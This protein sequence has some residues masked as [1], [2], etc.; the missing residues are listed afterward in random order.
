MEQTLAA[1]EYGPRT[2][3]ELRA[4]LNEMAAIPRLEV[5]DLEWHADQDGV[6]LGWAIRRGASSRAVR[7][8]WLLAP[9][10][11]RIRM[12]YMHW[13]QFGK[14]RRLSSLRRLLRSPSAIR[15][16]WPNLRR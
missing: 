4:R 6:I 12:Q 9:P 10:S 14:T 8:T 15:L 2:S 11:F 7:P 1:G 16:S 13:L 3:A 5:T